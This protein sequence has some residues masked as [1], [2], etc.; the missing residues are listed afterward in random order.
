[1]EIKRLYDRE[2]KFLRGITLLILL[3]VIISVFF[4]ITA[5]RDNFEEYLKE[6]DYKALYGYLQNPG[7]SQEIFNI[8][9]DY[10]YGGNIKVIEKKSDEDYKYYKIGTESGEKVIKLRKEK[11]EEEWIFDDYVYNW[12][13]KLPAAA[14]I[15][16]QNTPVENKNGQIVIESIPFAVYEINAQVENCDKYYAR[17]LAGQKVEIKMNVSSKVMLSCRDIISQYLGFK[18]DAI[19]SK[20]I[21]D[22]ACVEKDS[23]V[24]K[25]VLDQVEWLKNNDYSIRKDL[26]SI[27]IEKGKIEDDGTICVDI[28][29]VWNST[30]INENG[31]NKTTETFNNSYFIKPGSSFI[32]TKVRSIQM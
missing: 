24:Y 27:N 13:I 6:K 20:V 2:S 12:S 21:K 31:E 17:I 30:I 15:F 11:R 16:L 29:E 9:M 26:Q 1:M 7:F 8:Y 14:D 23:G 4:Y 3:G 28:M 22:I 10:N 5:S 25:E 19:N 32:I 18:Q